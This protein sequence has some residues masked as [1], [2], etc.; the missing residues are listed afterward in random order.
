MNTPTWSVQ[1]GAFYVA[2]VK[3]D[4]GDMGEVPE[5]GGDVWEVVKERGFPTSGAELENQ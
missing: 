5:I 4:R 1:S 2:K 3:I